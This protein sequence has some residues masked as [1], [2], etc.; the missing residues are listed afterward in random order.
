MKKQTALFLLFLLTAV[1]GMAFSQSAQELV[2]QARQHIGFSQP[3][4]ALN[5]L[6]KALELKPA[7]AEAYYLK[8]VVY[9]YLLHS[10]E[11]ALK[12]FNKA[13]KLNPR[14]SD[15][16]F[17]RAT[18]LE[19]LGKDKEAVKDYRLAARLGSNIAK[20]VLKGKGIKW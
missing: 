12:E 4:N 20:Q 9:Y 19:E 16:Y 6:D 13:I 14:N 5:A 17:D 3:E 18:A 2:G 7:Y 8:G 15:Y 10:S 11:E 1:P